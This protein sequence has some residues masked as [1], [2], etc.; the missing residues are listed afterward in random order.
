MLQCFLDD[1][2]HL[3]PAIFR[4]GQAL[5]ED[6]C[7]AFDDLVIKASGVGN[8]SNVLELGSSFGA[9]A[10]RALKQSSCRCEMEAVQPNISNEIYVRD[11]KIA[12]TA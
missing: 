9:L 2:M 4:S 10:S 8:D 6:A 5:L 1:G 11:V 3:S 12:R 7:A